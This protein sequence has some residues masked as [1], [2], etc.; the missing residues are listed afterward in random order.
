[1]I[2]IIYNKKDINT[3]SSWI[4]DNEN[5]YVNI[6]S[7]LTLKLINNNVLL[8]NVFEKSVIQ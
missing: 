3:N 1:M 5:I 4:I 7:F 8:F 6:K 2:I